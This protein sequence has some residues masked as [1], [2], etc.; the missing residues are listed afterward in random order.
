MWIVKDSPDGNVSYKGSA[1]DFIN[2][3]ADRLKLR[4]LI[5]LNVYIIILTLTNYFWKPGVRPRE[6]IRGE[7]ERANICSSSSTY[8]QGKYKLTYITIYFFMLRP[9]MCRNH[10]TYI[11]LIH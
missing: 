10:D 9:T 2:Y 4:F 8:K 5:Q 11:I 6:Y 1:I 7:K 3:F